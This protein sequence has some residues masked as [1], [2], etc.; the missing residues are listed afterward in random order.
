MA[1]ITVDSLAA[2]YQLAKDPKRDVHE[3]AAALE[4]YQE[5]VD[6]LDPI[7]VG[8]T[9][10]RNDLGK[11]DLPEHTLGWQVIGWISEMIQLPGSLPGQPGRLTKEQVRFFLWWFAV[12]DNGEFVYRTGVLQRCKGWGKDPVMAMLCL[13]EFVGPARF[14]HWNPLTGEP[15]AMPT[16]DAWVQVAAVSK[17][18][19]RNTMRMLPGFVSKHMAET[20]GIKPG[21]ELWRAANGTRFLE[22]VTS[23]PATIEGGRS[24]FVC[25]NETHHWTSSNRGTEM[26][27]VIEGNVTKMGGRWLA[28]TNAYLP[29]QDSVAEIMREAW[30][31]VQDGRAVDV[32]MFYDS[33]EADPRSPMTPEAMRI[34][35][36][37]VFGD[38]VW[39]KIE[40]TIKSA[41]N[42]ARAVS[43]SRRMYYN[44][45]VA[46]EDA[47]YSDVEWKA[48]EDRDLQLAPGDKIVLGFDGSKSRDATA[49]VALR[50]KDMAAFPLGVWE[51][52]GGPAGEGWQ[53]DRGLVNSAVLGAVRRFKV[54]GMYA[55]VREWESYIDDWH[56][57]FGGGLV[58]QASQQGNAIAW[59]MRQGGA[60]PTLAHERLVESVLE[61]KLKH[62]GNPDLRRHVLN[63]RRRENSY[64]VSFGKESES[65]EKKVDAYAALMLAHEC[66]HDF[67][68]RRKTEAVHSG[69]V[70]FL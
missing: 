62:D 58:V 2:L 45:I 44:Q 57:A 21:A 50:V 13:V 27:D 54:V 37:K 64:G 32:G 24:T 4:D 38:A 40:D 25:L 7:Y 29:G 33:I 19:T 1:A 49:L 53:V 5:Q 26:Y 56:E 65:S 41:L 59:D 55:D 70:W 23:N 31:D 17:T 35:L 34:I 46:S 43:K 18:Q 36:P 61:G 22:S 60:K 16:P 12:D 48:C 69:E 68:T 67:R 8:P 47:V 15:V 3:R 51:R 28:I 52:P 10:R 20:Y 63:A 6:L 14:S 9:W 39:L 11:W 42:R 30:Q 66:L